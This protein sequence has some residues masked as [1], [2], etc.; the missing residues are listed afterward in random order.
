MTV[1]REDI[2]KELW[3]DD[4]FVDFDTGINSCVRQIR[5][6]LGDDAEK[7]RFIETIPKKG[8]RFVAPLHALDEEEVG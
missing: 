1:R 8:Y 5:T 2:Q 6:A 3:P 4:T 7:P